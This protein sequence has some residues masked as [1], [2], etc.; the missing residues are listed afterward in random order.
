[1]KFF[2]RLKQNCIWLWHSFFHGMSG[3]EK[4]IL[5]NKKDD[6][7]IGVVQEIGGGGVFADMLEQKETQQVVE[8]R[9][10]YYRVLRE[11]D[12]YD[13]S[14]ITIVSE[15]AETGEIV[16]GNT[17][18][19]RKK[20]KVD[21][22]KHPPVFNPENFELRTIQD[23]KQ[24]EKH[25]SLLS[26][27]ESDS[28][29]KEL[30]STSNEFDTTL[31]IFRDSIT[32][33]FFLEKY[34]KRIVVRKNGERVFLD[35]YLPSESSLF[36]KIDAILIS[37]LHRM[38]ENHDL[39]S[40]ITDVIGF[41]WFSDKA[42]NSDDVCFFKYDDV[43][44]IGTNIFDGSFVLTFN[45]KVVSDGKYLA[46]KYITKELDEKYKNEEQKSDAVN[47][48]ALSRKMERDKAKKNEI[49]VDNLNNT[50][51]KIS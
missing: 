36:G 10:K 8:T 43:E 19:V 32:P 41:E 6:N 28:S 50:T 5:S 25:K 27:S 11:A 23:N 20:T 14:N 9:D 16:F 24:I 1:M 35:L 40:D 15:D 7:I 4:A 26:I 21:F 51:L 13:A 47:I 18:S 45:C 39:K 31:T 46:D 2:N 42:W 12:K 34:V 3:A 22:M 33:R 17:N 38:K 48:F 30:L 37:N 49:D 29:V 44:F